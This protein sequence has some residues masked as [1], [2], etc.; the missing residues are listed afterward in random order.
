MK[1]CLFFYLGFPVKYMAKSEHL[2][3]MGSARL[4]LGDTAQA[5]EDQCAF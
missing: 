4:K 5:R 2:R 1:N 3:Q